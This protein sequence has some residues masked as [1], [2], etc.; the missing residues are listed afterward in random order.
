[1]LTNG[2]L[3]TTHVQQGKAHDFFL[4]NGDGF[5][6]PIE[7][8]GFD[9]AERGEVLRY[10]LPIGSLMVAIDDDGRAWMRHGQKLVKLHPMRQYRLARGD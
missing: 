6:L 3:I 8:V 10:Q 5:N 9:A 7:V 4:M 2:A 1:V